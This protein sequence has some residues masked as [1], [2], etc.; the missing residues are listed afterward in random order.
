MKI[1]LAGCVIVDE[2]DR[3][4]LLHR[5][6]AKQTQ[7]E[8]PGG[9]IK[10]GETAEQA[11]VRELGEELGVEVR[12]V[13]ALGIGEFETEDNEYTYVWFQA[14][15]ESGNPT[16]FEPDTFDGFDYF[17]IEDMLSL[18]LSNNMQVLI[19]KIISGDVALAV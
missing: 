13:K 6:T 8:L 10:R 2:Y 14:V 3:I 16:L 5:N 12:L 7:W 18:A 9:K 11:A 1:Q 4:L 19:D 17:D 15:I